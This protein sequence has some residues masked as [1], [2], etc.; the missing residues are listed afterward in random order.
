MIYIAT[1]LRFY[2]A[3]KY[4][5]PG[6]LLCLLSTVSLAAEVRDEFDGPALDTTF[7][8]IHGSGS[9]GENS[10]AFSLLEGHLQVDVP[11]NLG[12]VSLTTINEFSG[13]VE[14]IL[15]F[16]DFLASA[17]SFSM[18]PLAI[19][20]NMTWSDGHCILITLYRQDG[21]NFIRSAFCNDPGDFNTTTE[22]SSGQLII[23]R[24]DDVVTTYY[25]PG[26]GRITLG[27][28][29]NVDTG[30][31]KAY[32]DFQAGDNGSMQVLADFFSG[33]APEVS[34]P[35]GIEPDDGEGDGNTDNG[36]DDN[37]DNGTDDNTDNGTDDN[38][39]DGTGDNTDD[40]KGDNTDDGTDDNTDDG[41]SDGSDFTIPAPENL[42]VNVDGQRVTLGW[43]PVSDASGYRLNLGL[44]SG[45]YSFSVDVGGLT[46]VV[47]KKAPPGNY[48]LTVEAYSELATSGYSNEVIALVEKE[49]VVPETISSPG[50]FNASAEGNTVFLSWTKSENATGYKLYYGV[51]SGQYIG[52][53]P[54][55]D[56]STFSIPGIPEGTYYL[57]LSAY[58][59]SLESE[60]SNELSV[61]V[62]SIE[63]IESNLSSA[64]P[65]ELLT[66]T[67]SGSKFNPDSELAVRFFDDTGYT[68]DVPVME[69]SAD[70]VTVAVPFLVDLDTG[71]S[72]SG[73]VSLQ[74]LQ[75]PDGNRRLSSISE[76]FAI[77]S[78][79]SSGLG[80]GAVT[81]EVLSQL[82]ALID[83]SLSSLGD[84]KA[85]TGDSEIFSNLEYELNLMAEATSSR[86]TLVSQLSNG[87]NSYLE[88]GRV[89]GLDVGLDAASL[90]FMDDMYVTFFSGE[91]SIQ[92][93]SQTTAVRKAQAA[94]DAIDA[95]RV[96]FDQFY[97]NE[98][99]AGIIQGVKKATG[100]GN[101]VLGV[102]KMDVSLGGSAFQAT[103]ASSRL[104][105]SFSLFSG[106]YT[107]MV[108][109]SINASCAEF[110]DEEPSLERYQQSL[111]FVKSA[112]AD[113]ALADSTDLF[114]QFANTG[115]Y[116]ENL[117]TMHDLTKSAKAIYSED[118][119]ETI[120][121]AIE[122]PPVL[123]TPEEAFTL[124]P[125]TEFVLNGVEGGPFSPPS[126]TYILTN[127]G[128]SVIDFSVSDN[129][130]WLSVSPS[131]GSLM[132]GANMEITLAVNSSA[133][134]LE[135][136]SYDAVITFSDT[137]NG[138]S[139][140]RN[141]SLTIEEEI[142]NWSVSVS[143]ASEVYDTSCSHAFTLSA[144][145]GSSGFGC[146]LAN[147]SVTV[148]GISSF[149]L[150]ASGFG[151]VEGASCSG[152]ASGSS[153]IF[154]ELE[155]HGTSG[156]S[157]G[158]ISCDY[159]DG[160]GDSFAVTVT[161]SATGTPAE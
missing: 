7:W 93:I 107:T 59:S 110:F 137:N 145:G 15:D 24:A 106:L 132:P 63:I 117:Q 161:Y 85:Q 158:S 92:S 150:S 144:A 17:T 109:G 129:A 2:C 52:S 118:L 138:I 33:S 96:W 23:S 98:L 25:D 14:F 160:T 37:T 130:S 16:S 77:E 56:R 99:P 90:S 134:A 4:L 135:K 155:G 34:T 122:S 75:N 79:I 105:S 42:E 91:S 27:T 58:S 121:Q 123:I 94:V 40:G 1:K 41:A 84:I 11:A 147:I 39:D 12:S 104:A 128:N 102:A 54:L 74:L 131:A 116:F 153:V 62:T 67:I 60:L 20:L 86:Q 3:L 53:A 68:V 146:G 44:V 46:A 97:C 120:T 45:N 19:G 49:V 73:A 64:I 101:S 143:I 70:S 111:D 72:S 133:T 69:T 76:G 87:S 80:V 140:S 38:T 136:G 125:D 32:L 124:G 10:N 95:V 115:E 112:I 157:G 148:S 36:T 100:L 154:S 152:S 50:N 48:Y 8:D 156:S 18:G 149:S 65:G 141:A 43:S 71:E 51:K 13:D 82:E 139:R 61:N 108:V 66:L 114:K 35:D 103:K 159:D 9:E 81:L 21:Q 5:V 22:I 89:N 142:I 28:F 126:A 83:H 78:P 88:L 31:V 113:R 29:N 119:S 26:D 127:A 57:A 6:V 47:I 30:N 55:G 151:G